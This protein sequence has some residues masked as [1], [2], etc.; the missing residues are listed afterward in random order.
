MDAALD[1]WE[2]FALACAEP[3]LLAGDFNSYHTFLQSPGLSSAAGIQLFEAMED[4]GGG[5][6]FNDV[7][8]PT[9]II[10]YGLLDLSFV[11]RHLLPFSVVGAPP[12]AHQ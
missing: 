11:S 5:S 12:Y 4:P 2:L 1:L 9:H 8:L 7:V 6:L 10:R 3:L